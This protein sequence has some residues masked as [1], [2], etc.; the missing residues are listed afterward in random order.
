MNLNEN[1]SKEFFEK[2]YLRNRSVYE[3]DFLPIYSKAGVA[4]DRIF[5]TM[6]LLPFEIPFEDGRCITMILGENEAVTFI[7]SSFLSKQKFFF[8]RTGDDSLKLDVAKTFVEMNYVMKRGEVDLDLSFETQIERENPSELFDTCIEKLNLVL[9]SY[10]I[11]IKDVSIYRLNSKMLDVLCPYRF[12][13]PN[14]WE[15]WSDVFFLHDNIPYKK[16]SLSEEDEYEV[17]SYASVINREQNPFVL[18]LELKLNATRYFINGQFREAILYCQTAFE[19][20]LRTL[21][22]ELFRK[23]NRSPDDLDDIYDKYGFIG[24]LKREFPS[25]LGGN[26]D[27]MNSQSSLRAWYENCYKR[28]N[29]IIHG[30]YFPN[31]L[32]T[33]EALDSTEAAIVY[34]LNLLSKKT[35]KYRDVYEY[36]RK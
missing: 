13:N 17:V 28:R 3:R 19:M 31:A 36:L 15:S 33:K 8:D 34:I 12:I 35:N 32:E 10:L 27:I 14:N 11:V 7:F 5:Q 29:R 16:T 6:V 9:T 1:D 20:F 22:S 24:V 25:R 2:D 26:W 30:G 23:E 21:L 18:S 4:P